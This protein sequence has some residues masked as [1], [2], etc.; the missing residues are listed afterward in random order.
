MLFFVG[1]NIWCL[2][3]SRFGLQIYRFI[4]KIVHVHALLKPR[5]TGA[6]FSQLLE[7]LY[8]INIGCL[9]IIRVKGL[10]PSFGGEQRCCLLQAHKQHTNSCWIS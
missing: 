4:H 1:Y 2:K 5:V 6:N 9:A 3:D 7:L 10:E 8:K